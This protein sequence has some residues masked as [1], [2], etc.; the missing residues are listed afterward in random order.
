[1]AM[2]IPTAQTPQSEHAPGFR[3]LRLVKTLHILN[4]QKPRHHTLAQ[5]I[6]NIV[7]D[8]KS[9]HEDHTYRRSQA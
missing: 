4:C 3:E 1:M 5:G 7:Q 2:Q 6:N 8:T 9:R